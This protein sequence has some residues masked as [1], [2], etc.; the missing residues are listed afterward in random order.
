VTLIVDL[1]LKFVGQGIQKL[2]PKEYMIHC[3]C[4]LD[5]DLELMTLVYK[6]G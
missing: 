5:L 2:E 1:H 4:D 6:L 3:S